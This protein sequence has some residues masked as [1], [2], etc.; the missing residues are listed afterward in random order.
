MHS[1]E[2]QRRTGDD[3]CIAHDCNS[4]RPLA[5]FKVLR[6]GLRRLV[7]PCCIGKRLGDAKDAIAISVGTG[8]NLDP[9][10]AVAILIVCDAADPPRRPPFCP[11][12]LWHGYTQ[13]APRRLPG[14]FTAS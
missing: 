9:L 3:Q 2:Q 7:G 1:I 10:S 11:R 13:V 4:C 14:A 6:L 8:L 12:G 5:P